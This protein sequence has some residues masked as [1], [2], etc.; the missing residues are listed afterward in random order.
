[1]SILNT[2]FYN[3]SAMQAFE[4]AAKEGYTG[5]VTYYEDT[6]GL[7]ESEIK[8]VILS[9]DIAGLSKKDLSNLSE[10]DILRLAQGKDWEKLHY[11]LTKLAEKKYGYDYYTQ[12]EKTQSKT[13]GG[14]GG[15]SFGGAR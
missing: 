11:E 2:D 7:T 5:Y 12:R 9:A 4:S 6:F 13:G 15:V 14:G 3:Q 8:D 1:V 10:D